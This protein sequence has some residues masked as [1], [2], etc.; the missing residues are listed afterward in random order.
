[1][2]GDTRAWLQDS[3]VRDVPHPAE[4]IRGGKPVCT[5]FADGVD[6]ADCYAA[7]V[8]RAQEVYLEL[9]D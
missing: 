4:P 6:A 3:T 1:V 2:V 8:R 7:L 9:G 5:V